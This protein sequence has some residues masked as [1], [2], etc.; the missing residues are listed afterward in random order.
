MKIDAHRFIDESMASKQSPLARVSLWNRIF[1]LQEHKIPQ[2]KIENDIKT[3]SIFFASIKL[4]VLT[5][6]NYFYIG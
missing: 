6:Y 3:L 2:V 5:D 4:C 1:Q